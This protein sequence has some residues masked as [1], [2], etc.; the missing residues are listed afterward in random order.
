M[1]II[2]FIVTVIAGYLAAATLGTSWNWPDAGAVFA[3]AVMGAF[4][5]WAV[6]HPKKEEEKDK[7]DVE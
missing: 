4:I 7:T 2:A 6:R 1:E 3:V 5:L